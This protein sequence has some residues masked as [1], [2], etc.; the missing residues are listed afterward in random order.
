MGLPYQG[1]AG[2][3][4]MNCKLLLIIILFLILSMAPGAVTGNEIDLLALPWEE[5]E[6]I[7]SGQTVHM[8]MWGGNNGTNNFI[9]QWIAPRLKERYHISLERV[10]VT[11][12]R[13]M[14]IKILTEK[15]MGK[16]TG[17]ADILWIN[18]ENFRLAMEKGLLW[19]P[20]TLI[21]PNYMRYVDPSADDLNMDF[22]K[23]TEGYEAPWG[24]A[25]FVMIC[26]SE[27]VPIPPDTMEELAEFIMENPGRFTYPSPPDFTGSC[28]IRQV[29]LAKTSGPGN[30]SSKEGSE[31]APG[32]R[33]E[34][35]N[36][37]ND[38]KP[39]LWRQGR[40]YPETVGILDQLYSN[41]E[42]WFTMNY[43]P[44]HAFNKISQGSFPESSRTFL[45]RN[46]T[47]SNTHYLTIPFNAKSKAGALVAIDLFLS[48]EGQFEKL[49]P[50]VW[51]DGIVLDP[52][53]MDPEQRRI[54]E[55]I[56]SGPSSLSPEI[57]AMKRIPEFSSQ[58]IESIE[59]EWLEEV[60][61]K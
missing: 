34:A 5:I 22:G 18:G 17:S 9:D 54:L 31:D 20:F 11:D 16:S 19:A 51:G 25:Q 30:H 26:N 29:I 33:S 43:N 10:P 42:V 49:K 35:W 1:N 37:L 27:F 36:F 39:C 47:F 21:L 2:G 13:E 53:R 41:G 40:T 3:D 44:L 8:Y 55:D 57:L 46:G 32:R 50:H 61:K 56:G 7:A 48:P 23:A 28:F 59:K 24:K 38:L 15:Q 45:F 60:G 58:E 4:M 52:S 14:I 12:I 6:A